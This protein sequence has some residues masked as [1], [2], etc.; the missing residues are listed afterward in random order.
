MEYLP[1]AHR[2]LPAIVE[3]REVLSKR[4]VTMARWEF[5]LPDIGEGVT[6]G[7]IVDVAR[8]AGR[9]REGRPAD[10]RGDDRQGDGDDRRAARRD[11]SSRLA[12]RSAR[13]LPVHSVLVVFE[14]DARRRG[15][16]GDRRTA[17]ADDGHGERKR[18]GEEGRRAGGDGRR[19]HPRELPGHGRDDARAGCGCAPANA[20]SVRL[21][22]TTSRSRRR[23]R[24]RL[25]RE[26]GR[27]SQE[28]AADRA[29]RARDEGRRAAVHARGAAS[30][31]L[32]RA[33]TFG[34]VRRLLRASRA[35]RAALRGG[36]APT[37]R[38]A[39][40]SRGCAGRSRRRCSS[41]RRPPRT[42][43]SSR[44]ATSPR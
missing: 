40:R 11:A 27:R 5:K 30:L 15:D 36:A 38:S 13:S 37:P 7:E 6:E 42:S 39:F 18:A 9:R 34:A 19:R 26:L 33:T 16:D 32:H 10:G 8:E 31:R 43:R 21:T 44:S 35:R 4:E 1:L 24:A 29:A 28:R 23:R 41:R 25:A 14:L 3:T 2:I 12:A 22:S 17:P 20:Q